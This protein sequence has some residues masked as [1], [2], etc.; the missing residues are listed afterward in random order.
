MIKLSE[1]STDAPEG[2]SK[3][4]AIKKRN[5]LTKRLGELQH[6]LYA[7]SKRSVLV[8]FQGMDASGKDGATKKVFRYCSPSGVWAKAFKKPTEEE[9]AH[10]FLWRIHKH[11][12]KQGRIQI[13]NRSHYE[14]I[15]IQ[16]VHKWIDEETVT[17]R[18]A[19]INHWEKLLIFDNDT[20]VIKFYMHLSRERQQEKLQERIDVPTKNWKHNPGDWEEAKLWDKYMWAYEDAINRCEVPW[21]IVPSDRR[22]Y[23]DYFVAKTVVDTLEALNMQLPVLDKEDKLG[24]G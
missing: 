7:E 24:E 19:A 5:A 12:P 23:R 15:L 6:T 14:D 4:E 22:W 20:T 17:K 10:D 9:F 3:K 21:H 11:A 18:I 2:W 16:R 13:F 1:I 8:V